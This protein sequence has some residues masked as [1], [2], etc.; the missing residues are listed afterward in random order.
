[1]NKTAQKSTEQVTLE[2]TPGKQTKGDYLIGLINNWRNLA[3]LLDTLPVGISISTNIFCNEI[4]HNPAAA[5]FFRIN[6]WDNHS[7]SAHEKPQFEL[8]HK[9]K[10]LLPE[11]MPVQRSAW[12]GVELND[13]EV[14]IAWEDGSRKTLVLNSSPLFDENGQIV[15]AV[16][17]SQDITDKKKMENEL[18]KHRDHLEELVRERT[19]ELQASKDKL[20]EEISLRNKAEE[21]LNNFFRFSLDSFIIIGFDGIIRRVNQ[22]LLELI[23]CSEEVFLAKSLT[24]LVYYYVHPGHQENIFRIFKAVENGDSFQNIEFQY[25]GRGGQYRWAS[26][27]ITQLVDR[28]MIY[29]VGRDITEQKK[30]QERIK[31]NEAR[32]EALIKL[33]QM[34]GATEKEICLFAFEEAI[35]LTGSEI[36]NL[37]FLNEDE[38]AVTFHWCKK[39]MKECAIS[40]KPFVFP[41]KDAGLWGETVRQRIPIVVNDYAAPN[42]YKKGLPEGHV[43]LTSL[44]GLPVFDK[45][46]IVAVL[47]VVNKIEPY[48][49]WDIN[50]LTLLMGDMWEIIKRKRTEE[51][52]RL[53]EERF[54]K[55]FNASPILLS[56]KRLSDGRYIDVN[57]SFE[58][59]CGY[60]REEIIGRTPQ[61][62]DFWTV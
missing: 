31:L 25:R 40:D 8:I 59:A 20:E 60:N 2:A 61:E 6:A 34:S 42:L 32:M 56:I 11:E 5:S 18:S 21:E 38:S 48:V 17:T 53:S 26:G 47:T 22:A 55:A 58:R 13:Y 57:K 15:G 51:E 19:R 4:I 27:T 1:M 43:P 3:A 49:D 14:D 45:N 28:G 35:K 23:D 46:R 37:G 24:D 9:G 41:I 52:L 50:Q 62:F 54:A 44:L 7:H 36:G 39:A 33:N 12:S 16:A 29:I 30:A 10:V